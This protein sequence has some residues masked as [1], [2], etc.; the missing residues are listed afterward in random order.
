MN[1][2]IPPPITL[3]R[4]EAQDF[5]KHLHAFLN[6]KQLIKEGDKVLV[7]GETAKEKALRL[8]LE[9]NFV[10]ELTSLVVV[11]DQEEVVVCP[12]REKMRELPTHRSYPI[13]HRSSSRHSPPPAPAS[14]GIVGYSLG[15]SGV[16]H[17]SGA[18]GS[19]RGGMW[20]RRGGRRGGS[21]SRSSS[22][23]KSVG[24][25]SSGSIYDYR[26]K[27]SPPAPSSGGS[28]VAHSIGSG[29]SGP[30]F[31]HIPS[32]DM[33]PMMYDE[34]EES[35]LLPVP[36]PPPLVPSLI[37]CNITMYSK[38]YHR[39]ENITLI[40]D[41]PDLSVMS[42]SDRLVSLEVSGPCCWS[43]YSLPHYQG[44][45]EVFRSSGTYSSTTSM[46]KVFRANQSAK[47]DC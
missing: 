30:L 8:S 43:V 6:I 5:M 15:H 23:M 29:S 28:I 7:G 37:S 2:T 44:T 42:F 14:S 3:Q 35:A 19:M 10:T 22:V 16:M 46:G 9:N 40:S 17:S 21:R 27:S 36:S 34:V 47:K 1:C 18:S 32:Y 39:G 12:G 13:S 33:S 25:G 45:R 24:S 11:E 26:S 4:S 31:S 38:T 41:T 20:G